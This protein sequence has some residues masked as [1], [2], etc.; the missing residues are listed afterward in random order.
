MNTNNGSLNG[1]GRLRDERIKNLCEDMRTNKADISTVAT[2]LVDVKIEMAALSEKMKSYQIAQGILTVLAT[3]I[4]A[5][6]ASV[7]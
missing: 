6:I 1:L 3:A 5:Y 4:A 7:L 2:E